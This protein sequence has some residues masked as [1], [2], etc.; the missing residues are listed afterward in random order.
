MEQLVANS[1][2]AIEQLAQLITR[3]CKKT[4]ADANEFL[5]S[6]AFCLV[7]L[8]GTRAMVPV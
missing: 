5:T 3:E 1:I 2:T 7:L 6:L 8:R 4:D